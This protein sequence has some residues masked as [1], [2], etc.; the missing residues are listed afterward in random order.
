MIRLTR[1]APVL[2]S[3]G[4]A[5]S[6]LIVAAAPPP[7]RAVTLLKPAPAVGTDS[8]GHEYLFWENS[9]DGLETA[10][11]TDSTGWST[12]SP[13]TVDGHGMGPLASEPTVAVDYN[14]EY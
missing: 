11:Y 3:L 8:T 9:N 12:P 2:A 7:A 13:V 14:T 5:A 1:I 10:K 4:L 6:A